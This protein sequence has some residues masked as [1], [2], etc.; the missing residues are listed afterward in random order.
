LV[1]LELSVLT[2]DSILNRR[3]PAVLRIDLPSVGGL[4]CVRV[5]EPLEWSALMLTQVLCDDRGEPLFS[6]EDVPE[7]LDLPAAEFAELCGILAYSVRMPMEQ[8]AQEQP[9]ET[10]AATSPAESSPQ[11]TGGSFVPEQSLGEMKSEFHKAMS[12]WGRNKKRAKKPPA[13]APAAA[14]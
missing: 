7:L 11:T 12:A 8:V 14:S 6:A 1:I 3:R 10:A 9:R 4:V 2:R 13:P 5:R